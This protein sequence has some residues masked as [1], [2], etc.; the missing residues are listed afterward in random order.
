MCPVS[1]WPCPASHRLWVPVTLKQSTHQPSV[2]HPTTGAPVTPLQS[3]RSGAKRAGRRAL[4]YPASYSMATAEAQAQAQAGV[5]FILCP[6][7]RHPLLFSFRFSSF[8]SGRFACVAACANMHVSVLTSFQL[9]L[10]LSRQSLKQS[11]PEGPLSL[12]ER[13]TNPMHVPR[14]TSKTLKT[15]GS[16]V[17]FC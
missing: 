5:S 7:V 17:V 12:P 11:T 4:R 10:A 16:G 2:S 9:V 1:A 6:R 8:V 14:G 13:F 15:L 3:H